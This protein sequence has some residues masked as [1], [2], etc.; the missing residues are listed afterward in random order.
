MKLVIFY[1]VF[2]PEVDNNLS[3]TIIII[4]RIRLELG[5]RI[6]KT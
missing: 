4:R 5:K 2:L 1:P 6:D 3:V